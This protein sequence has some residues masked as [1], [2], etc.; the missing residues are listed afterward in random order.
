MF[1][2][3]RKQCIFLICCNIQNSFLIIYDGLIFFR[4]KTNVGFGLGD[5]VERRQGRDRVGV[6]EVR[7]GEGL[8]LGEGVGWGGVGFGEG[9]EGLGEW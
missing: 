3:K 9:V 8:R 2:I 4:I 7:G 6:G 1:K 5:G